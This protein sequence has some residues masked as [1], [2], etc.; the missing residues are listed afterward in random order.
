MVAEATAAGAVLVVEALTVG[1]LAVVAVP[2]PG[3]SAA[4]PMAADSRGVAEPVAL[5][6]AHLQACAGDRLQVRA[7]PT[8]G[9]RIVTAARVIRHRAFI[10]SAAAKAGDRRARVPAPDR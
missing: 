3:D 9:S 10:R 5:A 2:M 4:A 8:P 7:H 6:E 1:V